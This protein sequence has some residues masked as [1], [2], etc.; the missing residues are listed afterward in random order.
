MP[1]TDRVGVLPEPLAPRVFREIYATGKSP[2]GNYWTEYD[3]SGTRFN[4]L[5]RVCERVP[6][7]RQWL[8]KEAAP[9]LGEGPPPIAYSRAYLSQFLTR[10]DLMFLPGPAAS[11]LS[12]LR[13]RLFR[14][15][16]IRALHDLAWA[17]TP[18]TVIFL[19]AFLH[20]VTW[21]TKGRSHSTDVA[22]S[23]AEDAIF[24][25][26]GSLVSRGFDDA[27]EIAI[28]LRE[29]LCGAIA[30]IKYWGDRSPP[31][32]FFPELE[33][34]PTVPLLIRI[35]PETRDACDCLHAAGENW[36]ERMHLPVPERYEALP[37]AGWAPTRASIRS[38]TRTLIAGVLAAHRGIASEY[39][40][41]LLSTL[42]GTKV[43]KEGKVARMRE[44]L[45]HPNA[46][47][48]RRHARR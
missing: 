48:T 1:T 17:A 14:A 43:D 18:S 3:G 2:D 19:I 46:S 26:C 32:Q 20:E 11:A 41:S 47:P 21:R 36:Y 23:I 13:P 10:H 12:H 44:R 16:Q 29:S 33:H 42:S 45:V 9:Y 28:V 31:S 39:E 8:F 34:L 15:L 35:T 7:S 5:E 30:S 25:F 40:R 24:R 22:A 6:A 37:D 27:D 4:L 38:A